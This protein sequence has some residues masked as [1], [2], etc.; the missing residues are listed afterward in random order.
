MSPA[1]SLAIRLIQ[2]TLLLHPDVVRDVLI[3]EVFDARITCGVDDSIIDAIEQE[4][5]ALLQVD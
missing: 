3:K 1:G 5:I 2:T 4:L